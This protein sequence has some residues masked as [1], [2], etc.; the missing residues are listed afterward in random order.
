MPLYSITYFRIIITVSLNQIKLLSALLQHSD[1]TGRWKKLIQQRRTRYLVTS[2]NP[3]TFVQSLSFMCV[4]IFFFCTVKKKKIITSICSLHLRREKRATK[5]LSISYS[6]SPTLL[7]NS[8][9]S[10]RSSGRSLKR[11]HFYL[12]APYVSFQ[13]AIPPPFFF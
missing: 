2:F 13:I 4:Y 10:I 11:F 12:L 8:K 5:T 6:L 1:Y 7:T 9:L 3:F